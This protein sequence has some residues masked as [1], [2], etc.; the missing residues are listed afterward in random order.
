VST[1]PEPPAPP[2]AATGTVESPEAATGTVEPDPGAR[3]APRA[4]LGKLTALSAARPELVVGAAF[5]GGVV[6]AVVLKRLGR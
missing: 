4:V 3:G 1:T 6:L 2:E 5:A